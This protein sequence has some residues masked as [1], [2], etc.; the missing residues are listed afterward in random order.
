VTVPTFDARRQAEA[1]EEELLEASRR[2]LLS[3]GYILGPEVQAFQEE[4]ARYLSVPHAIGVGS[5]TDALWLALRAV[6]VGSGDLVLTTPFTFFATASAILNCGATPVLADIEP[7]SFN[8]DPS[9][10]ERVLSG[11]DPVTQRLG[12]EPARIKAVVPVHLYGNPARLHALLEL[13]GPRELKVVEDAAQAMGTT[14]R[15]EH[16]GTLGDVG[17]YSFFPTK[18]L[19]AC[20]DAGLV[21]TRDEALAQRLSALRKHGS[22]TKYYHELVG[23]NSR[24]DALQAALLRAKLP[25]FPGWLEARREHARAYDAA[26]AEVAGLV[27]P[28]TV[29]GGVHSYHQYTLRVTGGRRDALQGHLQAQGIGTTVYYPVPLHLQDAMGCLGYQAGDFPHAEQACAEVLSLPMFPELTA[30]ERELVID[31]IQVFRASEA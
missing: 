9:A 29:E 11:R 24:L 14:Y 2:V 26:L 21:V 16:A 3:G 28:T 31:A 27:T 6:G 22:H 4:V 7:D 13:T 1:L 23:T 20:G 10:V 18:N 19:G 8:L 12:L 25:H 5:G 15:G 17:C 30:A